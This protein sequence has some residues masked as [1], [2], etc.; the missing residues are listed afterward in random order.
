MAFT[1]VITTAAST[2]WAQEKSATCTDGKPSEPVAT[3]RKAPFESCDKSWPAGDTGQTETVRVGV[4]RAPSLTALSFDVSVGLEL[5]ERATSTQGTSDRGVLDIDMPFGVG[6]GGRLS[7]DQVR[8]PRYLGCDAR[9]D[10]MPIFGNPSVGFRYVHSFLKDQMRLSFGGR[11]V[12]PVNAGEPSCAALGTVSSLVLGNG[13]YDLVQYAGGYVP[14]VLPISLEYRGPQAYVRLETA[15]QLFIP[16]FERARR[17]EPARF[18][19]QWAFEG[20]YHMPE[21]DI[22]LFIGARLQGVYSMVGDI[23]S[24]AS[25]DPGSTGVPG[26]HQQLALEPFLGFEVRAMWARV[27]FLTPL[28][29]PLGFGF[30]HAGLYTIRLTVGRRHP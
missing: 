5:F 7:P 25:V 3:A 2:V 28:D 8:A 4:V 20:A 10:L 6:L 23:G 18:V 19:P 21:G 1:A 13:G 22:R 24:F 29:R 15:G 27:G 17:D 30:D 11:I 14:L 9:Q 16:I 12:A 26:A